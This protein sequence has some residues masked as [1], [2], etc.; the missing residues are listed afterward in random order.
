M[1]DDGCGMSPEELEKARLQSYPY[2]AGETKRYHIGLGNVRSRIRLIFG[3]S[4]GLYCNSAPEQ[5]TTVTM[6]IQQKK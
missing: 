6:K 2:D 3:E 5:G 4:S 1:K